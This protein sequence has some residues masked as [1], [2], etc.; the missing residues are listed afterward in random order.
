V[1]LNRRSLISLDIRV[2]SQ[3]TSLELLR[4]ARKQRLL[5]PHQFLL[6]QPRLI[7][8][9]SLLLPLLLALLEAARH[10]EQIRHVFAESQLLECLGDVLTGDGL[11]GVLFRDLVGFG[12]YHCDELDAAFDEEVAT[13]FC[14]GHA[15]VGVCC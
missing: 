15:L 13:V 6:A 3:P 7:E 9:V 5:L 1:I 10:L 12:G 2:A 8:P 4:S 11:L 14:K